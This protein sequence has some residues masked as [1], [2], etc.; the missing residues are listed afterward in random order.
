MLLLRVPTTDRRSRRVSPPQTPSCLVKRSSQRLAFPPELEGKRLRRCRRLLMC[1]GS[2]R[3]RPGVPLPAGAP[4]SAAPSAG[5]ARC[6]SLLGGYSRAGNE[7]LHPLQKR[8]SPP[9]P[10]QRGRGEVGSRSSLS[11]PHAN[12]PVPRLLAQ[13][14]PA[15]VS[16]DYQLGL[17]RR[18]KASR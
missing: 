2:A 15:F 11:F 8:S 3:Q 16:L 4:G 18:P 12:E 6:A 13:V 9:P 10:P 1:A 5:R 7:Y 17:G 14:C